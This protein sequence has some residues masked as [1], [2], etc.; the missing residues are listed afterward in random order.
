MHANRPEIKFFQQFTKNRGVYIL[1][2]DFLPNTWSAFADWF[3]NFNSQFTV[4][5]G[6]YGLSGETGNVEKDN[7]WVQYWV[8]AKVA[9]KAQDKQLT[10]FVDAIANGETG[11]PQPGSPTWALPAG[12]PANVLPGVKKRIRSLARQIKA[13]P[14]YT[15]ADGA[16]LGIISPEE[17]TLSPETT[18]PELKCRP[19]SNFAVEIEFR[20]YG[21]DALRVELKHKSG[22]WQLASILTTSPGVFNAIP[23][24]PGDA[25][26]I[27]VRGIFLMKNQPFGIYSPIYTTVIQP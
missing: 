20:K 9:A 12:E 2:A 14:A 26:Q 23:Q 24:T 1:M 10:D 7:L 6:K 18:A 16:L 11:T 25:E 4:L 5:A 19:M 27:E 13:K 22:A 17:A 21:F 3:N 8:Q 15:V